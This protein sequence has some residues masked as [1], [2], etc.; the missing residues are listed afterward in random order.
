MKIAIAATDNHIDAFVDRHF[1]RCEWYCIFDTQTNNYEFIPNTAFNLTKG[2]GYKAI[3]LLFGK[4]I[5]VVIAGR[6]GS[7]AIETLRA[8]DIQMIIP[9]NQITINE[10]LKNCKQ[11]SN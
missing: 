10:I 9:E 8:K 11:N 3:D 1:G 2:A 6:F 7:R 5:N 4:S